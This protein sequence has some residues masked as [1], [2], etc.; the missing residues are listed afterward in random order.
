MR[1]RSWACEGGP[2]EFITIAD[3]GHPWA[4]SP[5]DTVTGGSQAQGPLTESLSTTDELVRF[6]REVVDD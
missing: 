1:R 3:H 5:E 6:V 4:G 2:L